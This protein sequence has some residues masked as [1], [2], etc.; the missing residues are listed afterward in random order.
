[1]PI[2]VSLEKV[3]SKNHFPNKQKQN[4]QNKTSKWIIF[5]KISFFFQSQNGAGNTNVPLGSSL[6]K[7]IIMACKI[8]S[9]K[10]IICLVTCFYCFGLKKPKT[11]PH[12]L[13]SVTLSLFWKRN[14]RMFFS[15]LG[16]MGRKNKRIPPYER[17]QMRTFK[18]IFS[19]LFF[20]FFTKQ[21]EKKWGGD[22][23]WTNRLW[24]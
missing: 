8:F 17:K 15:S 6:G 12:K 14:Q 10:S 11:S 2:L 18:K 21:P 24:F 1:M 13:C 5:L 3:T 19:Q 9:K 7:K 4:L 16:Q 22:G 20:F 23:E